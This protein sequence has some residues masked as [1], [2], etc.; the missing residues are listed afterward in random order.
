MIDGFNTP[1]AVSYAL[2]FE[3]EK[4]ALASSPLA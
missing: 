1:S 4:P 3:K 2:S